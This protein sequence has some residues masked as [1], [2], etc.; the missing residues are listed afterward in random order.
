MYIIDKFKEQ[1]LIS[2]P[3]MFHKIN[4]N[5]TNNLGIQN[6]NEIAYKGK[7]LYRLQ[8]DL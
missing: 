3:R 7:E 4:C 2:T 1:C 6:I 8:T 5:N